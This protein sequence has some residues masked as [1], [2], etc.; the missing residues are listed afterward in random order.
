MVMNIPEWMKPAA[1][2]GVIGAIAI[3]II[4]F[5][6]DWVVTSATAQE[7]AQQKKETAIIAALTPVCV[8]NFKALPQQQ[9]TM[10]LASLEEERT[11]QRGNYVEEQG[12]ATFPGKEKPHDDVADACARELMKLAEK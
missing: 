11:Y 10:E 2:G 7:M 4:G 5:S 8:A 3:T 6:S 1:W 9:E 12:W